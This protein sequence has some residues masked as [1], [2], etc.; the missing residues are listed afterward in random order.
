MR[1]T[2]QRNVKKAF[3][4]IPKIIHVEPV[5]QIGRGCP[6]TEPTVLQ[7]S[8]FGQPMEVLPEIELQKPARKRNTIT[9]SNRVEG[10]VTLVEKMTEVSVS[11][12]SGPAEKFRV[13]LSPCGESEDLS[14]YH[15]VVQ[16]DWK[17]ASDPERTRS[18]LTLREGDYLI[19]TVNQHHQIVDFAL[20][21]D[22]STFKQK[23]VDETRIAVIN[24]LVD[25]SIG[26]NLKVTERAT[27]L[28]WSVKFILGA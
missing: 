26:V 18:L 25:S 13:T 7:D 9:Y 17:S 21:E 10:Q 20:Q 2:L 16:A 6:T 12:I 27:A 3:T 5:P 28:K 22:D 23:I 24:A 14:C 19:A 4:A 8:V 11:L 15:T 1:R